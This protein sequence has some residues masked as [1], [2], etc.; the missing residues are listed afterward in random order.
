MPW[1]VQDTII[2]LW[3]IIADTSYVNL[4]G[5]A[6]IVS[7]NE[8]IINLIKAEKMENWILFK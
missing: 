5:I 7:Y 8:Q 2:Y 3:L 6:L 4:I 1:E